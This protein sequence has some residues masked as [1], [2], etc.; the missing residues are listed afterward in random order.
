MPWEVLFAVAGFWLAARAGVWLVR[1]A[2]AAVKRGEESAKLRP[3]SRKESSD[4]G[5]VWLATAAILLI[6]GSRAWAI[7]DARPI[8]H[9]ADLVLQRS[10]DPAESLQS[11]IRDLPVA[12]RTLTVFYWQDAE[13]PRD[14]TVSGDAPIPGGGSYAVRAFYSCE[15]AACAGAEMELSALDERG[16][17]LAQTATPLAQERVDNDLFWDQIELR[18]TAPSDAR[19]LR[20]ALHLHGGQGNLVIPWIALRQSRALWFR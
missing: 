5:V 12:G 10:G 4:A 7:R 20:L 16:R 8:L 9:A 2:S 11:P 6:L 3:L 15:T 17:A 14:A 19:R 1:R 13:P 18:I